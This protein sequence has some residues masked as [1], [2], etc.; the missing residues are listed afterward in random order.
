MRAL[1]TIAV[2]VTLAS[3]AVAQ[4]KKPNVVII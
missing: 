3:A 1:R 4:D 2:V